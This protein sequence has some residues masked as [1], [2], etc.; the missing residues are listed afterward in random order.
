MIIAITGSKGLIGKE[1]VKLLK[2]EYLIK[3]CTRKNCDITNYE[4]I[5]EQLR[6]TDIVIHCAGIKKETSK[7]IYN[8]N[9][10]G[11]MNVLKACKKNKVKQFIFISSIAVYGKE[12]EFNSEKETPKP[13]TNYGK[14]KFLAE[15]EVQKYKGHFS[16]TI[17]RP[18][19]VIENN[20]IIRLIKILY[21]TVKNSYNVLIRNQT[22]RQVIN[23][24]D[25]ARIV[26]VC[27]NNKLCY[28]QIYNVSEGI[29]FFRD[30]YYSVKKLENFIYE[31][32]RRKKN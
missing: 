24:E 21:L 30:R 12:N 8:V 10:E 13:I 27:I 6:N 3:E 31:S 17:L 23:V 15:L 29:N 5:E 22:K 25:L 20:I 16:I 9:L 2:K 32:K 28:G 26:K 1:L 14:S 18:S 4:Q 11:T 7:D 19:G